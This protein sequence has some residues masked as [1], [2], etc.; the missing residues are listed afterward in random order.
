MLNLNKLGK[1]CFIELRIYS[2]SV[3]SLSHSVEDCDF[4]RQQR[5]RML[6]QSSGPNWKSCVINLSMLTEISSSSSSSS[7]SNSFR[8]F[9]FASHDPMWFDLLLRS[10]IFF[11]YF[12]YSILLEL[13]SFFEKSLLKVREL[14]IKKK[15]LKTWK[16][17]FIF[18]FQF[19]KK[20]RCVFFKHIKNS[21]FSL[22]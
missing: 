11:F 5:S 8:K 17:K 2:C 16:N 3:S 15:A 13:N 14:S 7:S 12:W 22:K 6:R 18:E 4:L 9:A 19:R 1:Y 10:I 21:H 20:K